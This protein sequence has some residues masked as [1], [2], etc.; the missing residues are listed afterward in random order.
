M[1]EEANVKRGRPRIER[2][3]VAYVANKADAF[4]LGDDA[5]RSFDD[6]EG[7]AD[8]FG[9]S[10]KTIGSVSRDRHVIRGRRK[11]DWLIFS[12]DEK[13]SYIQEKLGRTI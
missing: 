12:D 9:L 13:V 3:Y 7:A 10:V 5:F 4:E 1:N 11:L 8:F 2:S 6:A